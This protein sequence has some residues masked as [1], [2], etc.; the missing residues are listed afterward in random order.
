MP[1]SSAVTIENNFSK[2]LITEATAMNYPENSVVETDNV[3]YTKNGKVIRRYGIDYETAYAIT[4]LSTMSIMASAGTPSD[5]YDDIVFTE[6]NWTTVSSDGAISFVVQQIGDRLVFFEVNDDNNISANRKTFSVDLDDYL[7]DVPGDNV[8]QYTAA[9]ECN[10]ASGKGY[11]FVTHPLCEPFYVEYDPSADDITVTEIAVQT[12]DFVRLNDSLDIDERPAT[13]TDTHEYNLWNQGW[14]GSVDVGVSITNPITDWDAIRTDFPSNAD[15]WWLFKDSNEEFDPAQADKFA[16]GNTAAPNGHYIYSAWDTDRSTITGNVITE[17]SSSDQRPAVCSFYAGRVWYSGIDATG[18]NSNLYFSKIIEDITDAGRCYQ[19]NDP[20]SEHNADLLP[21]DGG[22]V[23]IPEIERVVGMIAARSA[24]YVFCTNGI[25][26]ITGPNGIFTAEDYSVQRISN[27]SIVARNSIVVAEGSPIWWDT[28]GIYSIQFDP[29]S[30]EETVVNITEPTIQ[31]VI[32]E[33]PNEN[34]PYVKGTYNNINKTV[35]Y[36]YKST[37][38]N[39]TTSRYNYDKLLVLTLTNGSFSTHTISDGTPKV[40]GLIFT[41]QS[42]ND[43][44]I[45]DEGA[46]LVKFFTFGTIGASSATAVT[47]SQF[48]NSD[49][50]DWETFDGDGVDFESYFITGYRVRGDLL[51]K[52]Q[53]NYIVVVTEQET[54]AGCLIQGIWDYANSPLTGRY[55]TSQQVFVSDT[56]KDYS[57]RKIKIRGSGYSLQFKFRSQTG[58]PFTIVGWAVSETAGNVP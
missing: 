57:R 4:N 35:H 2:G 53:N 47:V 23:V 31:T 16:I 19:V 11:L 5:Y 8:G 37:T 13:L 43:D 10:F 18:Y 45:G 25:W 46:S 29:N 39:S 22:V 9:K 12:R 56:T 6:Y 28:A 17:N 42:N 27:I 21:S 34:L 48:N 54:N 55:T 36:I 40:C 20:T 1:R 24:L 7:V 15:V 33:I 32:N 3:V 30:G 49:Y 38:P 41:N 50:L 14:Y 58:K 44:L 51:R 26:K 52:F